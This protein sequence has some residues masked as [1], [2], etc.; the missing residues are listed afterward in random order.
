MH[1]PRKPREVN[2][3]SL[4]ESIRHTDDVAHDCDAVAH[5]CGTVT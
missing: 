3:F 1:T 5:D 4:K 2:K